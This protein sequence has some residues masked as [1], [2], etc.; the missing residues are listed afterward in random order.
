MSVPSWGAIISE[1]V[2]PAFLVRIINITDSRIAMKGVCI[3]MGLLMVG[4]SSAANWAGSYTFRLR[5]FVF[6]LLIF[7]KFRAFSYARTKFQNDRDFSGKSVRVFCARNSQQE[8]RSLPRQG[9]DHLFQWR[10]GISVGFFTETTG[11]L[12]NPETRRTPSYI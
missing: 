8:G 2:L 4:L 12:R 11:S 7:V 10:M 1:T 9:R 6:L 5:T 3:L